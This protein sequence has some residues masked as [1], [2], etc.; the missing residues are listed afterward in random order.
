MIDMIENAIHLAHALRELGL[1][2]LDQQVIVVVHQ[3]P[4]L[5]YPIEPL[6]N[7]TQVLDELQ[8]VGIIEKD[9]LARIPARHHVIE[10]SSNSIRSRRAIT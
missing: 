9:V 6:G 3:A 1:A 5:N 7:A 2:G 10:V 8:T 4:C